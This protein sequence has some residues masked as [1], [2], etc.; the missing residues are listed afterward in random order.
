M[1]GIA[2]F[3]ILISTFISPAVAQMGRGEYLVS[4]VM[5]CDG[6]HTPRGPSG[7][8][9]SRRFSGGSIV[10]DEPAFLVTGSNITQDVD[11]GIGNWT[12]DDIKKLLVDGVRPNGISVAHA[13]PFTFYK[14]LTPSDLDAVAKYVKAIPPI[15]REVTPPV[16]KQAVHPPI[17][18]GAEKPL[19]N[20]QDAVKRGFYLVTI[21]H[22][23]E[24]HSRKSNGEY[25]FGAGLGKGGHEMKG[26]YGSVVVRNISSSKTAGIGN[27]TDDEIKKSLT[28]GVG[29]DGRTFKPPMLRHVWYAKMTEGDVSDIIAYLRTIPPAE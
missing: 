24:C 9:M 17:P 2:S 15:R 12:V 3:L 11:T 4:A 20:A 14:I 18:P 26:P 8:D 19:T 27:W 23:M 5:A 13:M 6:C 28:Q 25:D 21:A 16:Y 22:C 29:R 10:W 7:L 1:R